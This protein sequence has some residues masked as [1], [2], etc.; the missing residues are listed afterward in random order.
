MPY[1]VTADATGSLNGGYGPE[2]AMI[3]NTNRK[4][5]T[6]RVNLDAKQHL[7]AIGITSP[8]SVDS[9][10]CNPFVMEACKT[11]G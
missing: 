9:G 7:R 1:G 10:F 4:K 5:T 3:H 6:R 8:V 11:F 2:K